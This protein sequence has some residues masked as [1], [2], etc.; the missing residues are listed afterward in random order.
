MV[1]GNEAMGVTHV[2]EWYHH[3]KIEVSLKSSSQ[4][5]LNILSWEWQT[6]VYLVPAKIPKQ[7]RKCRSV[8]V[9]GRT[10]INTFVNEMGT[11]FGS[12]QTILT[13]NLEGNVSKIHRENYS[14]PGRKP[15]ASC[16]CHAGMC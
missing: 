6:L 7:S 2:K 1:Y 4:L 3:F 13:D 11:L 15:I 8:M 16:M 10:A 12:V 14:W 5:S 9:Y